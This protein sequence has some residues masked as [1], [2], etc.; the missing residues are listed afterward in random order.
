[1]AHTIS[2]RRRLERLKELDPKGRRERQER[3]RK[4]PLLPEST[5][6]EAGGANSRASALTGARRRILHP[7][8]RK[9]A[10]PPG[11]SFPRLR[12][13]NDVLRHGLRQRVIATDQAQFL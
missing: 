12:D 2:E 5:V 6:R 11:V 3:P 10:D 13:L 1:M 4:P 7:L 8:E 9:R